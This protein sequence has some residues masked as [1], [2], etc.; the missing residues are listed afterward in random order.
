MDSV[1]VGMEW[2]F[3]TETNIPDN[4]YP[5]S[6][7]FSFN[8]TDVEATH[9]VILELHADQKHVFVT[10]PALKQELGRIESVTA[11][12]EKREDHRVS[13]FGTVVDNETG[14]AD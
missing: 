8:S 2:H 5:E 4:R 11:V 10:N 9:N 13:V 3:Q 1:P 7:S 12:V 14:G 6:S